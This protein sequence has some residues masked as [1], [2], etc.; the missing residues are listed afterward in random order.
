MT[1]QIRFEGPDADGVGIVWIDQ[2]NKKVNVL[3]TDSIPE[4]SALMAEITKNPLVRAIIIASGKDNSF[5]AGAD[6]DMLDTITSVEAGAKISSQGQEAMNQLAKMPIPV[7]A[8]I[9]GDCLGGGLE[10]ALACSARVATESPRT[11]LALPE[12]MLGLLPGAG[13]TRRLPRLIGL[14]NALDMMLTGKNIRPKKALKMGLVDRV[15]PE[16]KLLAAA[17]EVALQLTKKRLPAKPASFKEKVMNWAIDKIPPVQGMVFDKA[18]GAVLKQT[19]GLYPAPLKILEVVRADSDEAEAKGFGEL[20]MT[21]ESKGLRH[22]FHTITKLKKIDGPNTDGVEGYDVERIGI[23]GAGLMGGGIATVLSDKGLTVRLKDINWEGLQ[24]AIDYASAFFKKGVK[25]K[26]Y[27]REGMSERMNRLSGGLDYVGFGLTDVVIEAVPEILS[28]KQ[29]M[30]DEIEK[31]AKKNTIFATNT[32]S[33]PITSIAEKAAHP[34]RVIGM[35]FFSPVE[36]MPLVEII[37]HKGTD[38]KVTKTIS[39]LARKMGKHV[40]VVNDCAGFYVNRALVPYLCEAIFLI[41]DGYDILDIDLAA[42]EAGFP[43]GPIAL[44]DEVGI[45]VGAKTLKTMK[46]YYAD[47]MQ[48]PDFDLLEGFLKEGRLGKKTSKGFFKYEKGKSVIENGR[49]VVDLDCKRHLPQGIVQQAAGKESRKYLAER[50]I[51]AFVNEAVFCY[52]DGVLN[53]PMSADLGAVMGIGFL[54]FSG[55]PMAWLDAYGTKKFVSDMEDK[56]AKH[57]RRFAPCPLLV[58][59]A[60]TNMGIYAY[61]NA[62][63]ANAEVESEVTVETPVSEEKITAKVEA[64]VEEKALE[65]AKTETVAVVEKV[66]KA[67]KPAAKAKVPAKPKA[68]KKTTKPKKETAKKTEVA[69]KASKDAKKSK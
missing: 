62:K 9:H 61:H 32:S 40:I 33:L 17:K 23:L 47:R 13:G 48:F 4:I 30:V 51:S 29:Q 56:A 39:Q 20:L 37:T 11:K 53:D 16:T 24:A 67:K 41:L 44:M 3:N 42:E 34:E 49:K 57:G 2:P 19:K 60:E 28:L 15:V 26:R 5:V 27:S 59:L 21:A 69:K 18:R 14:P 46:E 36:K 65:V 45:D 31:G 68:A 35:H 50:M 55:G 43:V 63:N 58:E 8:A 54:P 6:I 38:P 25:R 10:L 66:E 7:V 22:L 1:K 64:K 52:Q 12:V